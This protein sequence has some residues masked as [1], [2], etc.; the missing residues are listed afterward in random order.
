M[1]KDMEPR[2]NSVDSAVL[3]INNAVGFIAAVERVET[4]ARLGM[5]IEQ[6][7]G[8]LERLLSLTL[9]ALSVTGA[10]IV[11]L[12]NGQQFITDALEEQA[13][14]FDDR[15]F[16]PPS[17][18]KAADEEDWIDDPRRDVDSKSE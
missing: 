14:N 11:D 6:R 9:Q 7:V 15:E 2:L 4:E 13:D 1:T 8:V 12:N 10:A 3:H 5:S 18:E 16:V 17:P